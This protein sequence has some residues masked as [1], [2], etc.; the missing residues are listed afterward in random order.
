MLM[1]ACRRI[2]PILCCLLLP[3]AAQ[4]AGTVSISLEGN[5]PISCPAMLPLLPNIVFTESEAG[6]LPVGKPLVIA[7]ANAEI[8]SFDTSEA[9][10]KVYRLADGSELSASLLAAGGLG[11]DPAPSASNV[12]DVSWSLAASSSSYGGPVRVVISGLRARLSAN[13]RQNV[14]VSATVGQAEG[15]G[16]ALTDLAMIG[17]SAN[18]SVTTAKLQVAYIPTDCLLDYGKGVTVS[19]PLKAQTIS[20]KYTPEPDLQG[21]SGRVFIAA[22]TPPALGGTVFFLNAAGGWEPFVSC[23]SAPAYFTGILDSI[24]S[25]PLVPSPL[26]LTP[27]KGTRIYLGQISGGLQ[28]LGA[29]DC[30]RLLDNP[31][32]YPAL[33]RHEIGN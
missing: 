4:A 14:A 24:A 28:G 21:R 16:S 15:S 25:I 13:P 19:G 6:A 3:A 32:I 17:T 30:H 5:T 20:L 33:M 26:D 12:A 8:A 7:A 9:T 11:N 27:L 10:L 18:A 1:T 2:G 22:A 29:S 31:L 23:D